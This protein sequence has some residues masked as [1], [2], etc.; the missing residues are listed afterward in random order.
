MGAS[1]HAVTFAGY[2]LASGDG[3]AFVESINITPFKPNFRDYVP[4]GGGYTIRRLLN[5][6]PMKITVVIRYYDLAGSVAYSG[7]VNNLNKAYI[8]SLINNAAMLSGDLYINRG[9]SQESISGVVFDGIDVIKGEELTFRDSNG[10]VKS[11]T[12]VE[13][14]FVKYYS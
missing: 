9:G 3:R 10:N 7:V 2:S 11:V 5:I 6:E 13:Y 8:S 1:L 4:P 12:T 14:R